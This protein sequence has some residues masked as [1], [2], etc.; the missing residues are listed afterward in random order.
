[1]S[2]ETKR[3]LTFEEYVEK[4][5]RSYISS[6]IPAS[7]GYW[8]YKTAQEEETSVSKLVGDI[9]LEYKNAVSDEQLEMR[10]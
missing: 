8:L 2:N 4:Y 1:M 3:T 7:L 9:L 10:D 5:T 6:Y